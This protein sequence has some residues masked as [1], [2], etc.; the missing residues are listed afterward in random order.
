M[1]AAGG[2]AVAQPPFQ[3]QQL[4]PA[5]LPGRALKLK[6]AGARW[7]NTAKEATS[8]YDDAFT[9][10][11]NVFGVSEAAAATRQQLGL[12][13]VPF[14]NDLLAQTAQR[15]S[16]GFRQVGPQGVCRLLVES[17]R[18]SVDNLQSR[19]IYGAANLCLAVMEPEMS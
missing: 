8:E 13:S 4:V 16:E 7:K 1:S 3:A 18:Q 9:L 17:I 19:Q 15:V 14:M 11:N 12:S 5:V 10:K 6:S 2:M